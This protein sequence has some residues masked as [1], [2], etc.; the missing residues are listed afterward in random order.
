VLYIDASRSMQ[1]FAGCLRPTQFNVT[2]DRLTSD[3]SI[4]DVVQFGER[5]R[6]SGDVFS[7]VA[8][9]KGVHCPVFY[10]RLQNPD[11]ALFRAAEEDSA[12]RTFLYLTDGVQSDWRGSNP[13]PSLGLL[14]EWVKQGRGLAILAFRSRFEGPLWSEQAQRMLP[15]VRTDSRPFYL[16]V[17]APTEDALDA[18]FQQLSQATFA[19]ARAMRFTSDDIACRTRLGSKVPRQAN[20]ESPPWALVRHDRLAKAPALL[21]YSCHL[22]SLYPLRSV[23]PKLTIGYRAWNRKKEAFEGLQSLPGGLKLQTD[24]ILTDGD[25]SLARLKGTLPFDGTTPYGLYQLRLDAL[26][27]E[28][29]PWIDSLSTDDDADSQ[30]FD[31][32]YRFSWLVDQL[33]RTHLARQPWSPFTL[34][35]Q[36][37]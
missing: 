31:R 29:R 22:R 15:V 36:Y 21:E 8:M 26:P 32:T 18:L 3:L 19:S 16:F 14:K 9:S 7:R 4:G 20:S 5:I 27:G 17:L 12:G 33:A 13:G 2:L 6:G 23:R 10:D 25:S 11:Y 34:T 28:L 24:T 30:M 1:G 35:I 37:R